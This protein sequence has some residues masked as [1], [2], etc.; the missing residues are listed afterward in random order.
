[1]RHTA[2]PTARSVGVSPEDRY[3]YSINSFDQADVSLGYHAM[4]S[5]ISRESQRKGFGFQMILLNACID[6]NASWAPS[7]AALGRDKNSPF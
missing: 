1:M 5:L 7:N 2:P 3:R 4:V 6:S